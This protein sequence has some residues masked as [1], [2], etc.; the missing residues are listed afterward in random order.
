MNVSV[1]QTGSTCWFN[2]SL[3]MFLTS[4]NG[5]KI[6]WQKLQETLPT[7]SDRQRAYFNAVRARAKR[8]RQA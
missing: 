8:A 5:L 4:D 3:N 7:L 2:S 1:G 6:L